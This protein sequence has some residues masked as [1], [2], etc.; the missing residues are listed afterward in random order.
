MRNSWL[1]TLAVAGFLAG[2]NRESGVMV[3]EYQP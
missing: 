2:L 3:T 1:W